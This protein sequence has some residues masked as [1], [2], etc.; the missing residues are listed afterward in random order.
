[1]CEV[2]ILTDILCSALYYF[3]AALSGLQNHARLYYWALCSFVARAAPVVKKLSLAISKISRTPIL[4]NGAAPLR[5]ALP[6]T[7]SGFPFSRLSPFV[8]K[9]SVMGIFEMAR[10]R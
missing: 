7:S 10:S 1:F 5:E 3:P 9:I 4:T 8:A 2:R 6:Y